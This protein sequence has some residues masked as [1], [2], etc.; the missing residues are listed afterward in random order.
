MADNKILL[1]ED[2]PDE[3]ELALIALKRSGVPEEGVVVARDGQEA[4]D[5]LLGQGKYA[6]RD[7][8][9]IPRVV[10]LDIN[11]PKLNGLEV[12]KRIR[13]NETT[14]IVPIVILTSSDEQRD[15]LQGY[16]LGANSFIRKAYDFDEFLANIKALSKYWLELNLT[17]YE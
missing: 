9:D 12:L 14:S 1:V 16:K 17:A 3:E 8:N 13:K 11:L 2:N 4:L 10:F 5:Y 6:S 15:L 7:V